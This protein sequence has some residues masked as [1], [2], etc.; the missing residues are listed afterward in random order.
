M[1][2]LP[3]NDFLPSMAYAEVHK[4]IPNMWVWWSTFANY[5]AEKKR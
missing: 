4:L 1:Q 2:M 5:P 3:N